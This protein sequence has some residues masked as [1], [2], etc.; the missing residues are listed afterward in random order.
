M[1]VRFVG[2][3]RVPLCAPRVSRLPLRLPCRRVRECGV[4]R[5]PSVFRLPPMC[6][7]GIH[8]P[9]PSVP[10]VSPVCVPAPPR[11]F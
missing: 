6:L 11:V 8:V 7:L 2:V 1:V 3:I 5:L 9:V 4:S 10:R